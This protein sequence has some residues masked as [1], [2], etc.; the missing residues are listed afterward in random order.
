M[1]ILIETS[2]E[3]WGLNNTKREKDRSAVIVRF[4]ILSGSRNVG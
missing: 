1:K 3:L 2:E 4:V